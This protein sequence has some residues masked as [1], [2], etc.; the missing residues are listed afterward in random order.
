MPFPEMSM[1]LVLISMKGMV[2]FLSAIE[3]VFVSVEK[4]ICFRSDTWTYFASARMGV[5]FI[6]SPLLMVMDE[7]DLT[8]AGLIRSEL[9]HAEEKLTLAVSLPFTLR[10]VNV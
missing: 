3:M 6:N 5:K 10:S 4:R 1:A 9:D 7:V 2:I 8:L